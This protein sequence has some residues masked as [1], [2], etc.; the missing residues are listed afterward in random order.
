M[1]DHQAGLAESLEDLVDE[2]FGL[3][4]KGD[5]LLGMVLEVGFHAEE[6][7]GGGAGLGRSSQVTQGRGPQQGIPE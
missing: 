6:L 5:Q 3:D 2:S 4:I 1:C 7:C